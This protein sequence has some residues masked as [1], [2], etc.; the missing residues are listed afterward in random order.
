MN[1]VIRIY[2]SGLVGP[3]PD[4]AT[5]FVGNDTGHEQAWFNEEYTEGER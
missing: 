2:V 5:V 3:R 1:L 4:R